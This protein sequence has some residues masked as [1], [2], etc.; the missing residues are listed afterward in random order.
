MERIYVSLG[1]ADF[2]YDDE[3]ANAVYAVTAFFF[4]ECDIFEAPPADWES[5]I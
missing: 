3:L 5:P 4:D 2:R 1:G